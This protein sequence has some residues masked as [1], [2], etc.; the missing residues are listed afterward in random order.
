MDAGTEQIAGKNGDDA[1]KLWYKGRMIVC[2]E[3]G[4]CWRVRCAALC[5]QL[6]TREG[7]QDAAAAKQ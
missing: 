3:G 6:L 7:Q 5:K 1:G 4:G 2:F